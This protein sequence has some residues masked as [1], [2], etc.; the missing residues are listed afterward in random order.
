MTSMY[1]LIEICKGIMRKNQ[2]EISVSYVMTSQHF[3]HHK[4]KIH[5]QSLRRGRYD[6]ILHISK[7]EPLLDWNTAA[8][9]QH[10]SVFM[11]AH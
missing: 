8:M 7:M 6:V 2:H 4:F 10:T 3:I 11:T 5:S 1:D 9:Q